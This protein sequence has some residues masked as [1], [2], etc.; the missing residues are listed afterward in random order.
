MSI[1]GRFSEFSNR[2][3]SGALVIGSHGVSRSAPVA[4]EPLELTYNPTNPSPQLLNNS[5]DNTQIVQSQN[6]LVTN[7]F[8]KESID[9]INAEESTILPEVITSAEPTIIVQE[10]D[11]L[12]NALRI[13]TAHS[14]IGFKQKKK[15][16][17][18][19]PVKAAA[20][21]G[22]FGI[23]IAGLVAVVQ[24]QTKWNIFQARANTESS[25]SITAANEDQFFANWI[26]I[27]FN[28]LV[29]KTGDEDQDGLTNYEEF[30]LGS[31]PAKYSTCGNNQSDAQNLVNLFDFGTCK[32]IDI[33]DPIQVA[34][35]STV[36]KIQQSRL[37][38]ENFS[39]SSQ[40][41]TSTQNNNLLSVF[42]VDSLDK[43]NISSS[44]SDKKEE[45][46]VTIAKINNYI[47]VHRSLETKDRELLPPLS[48]AYYLDISLRYNI[49]IKYIV[50]V[51][52]NS[53]KFGTDQ[54]DQNGA[55]NAI[56][57]S[58]N[59][60]AM[61]D[62]AGNLIKYNSWQESLEALGKWYQKISSTGAKD[63]DLWQAYDSASNYCQTIK[64]LA[65][66]FDANTSS[67][68]LSSSLPQPSNQTGELLP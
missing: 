37:V 22:V 29:D 51:A 14:K 9:K 55:P 4:I 18:R 15:K 34:K 68:M 1:A 64:T 35:I 54:Y 33:N 60:I 10:H 31:D 30:M 11:D 66:N 8:D 44:V 41:L 24:P 50:S 53:S 26:N 48:G 61:K 2:R 56:L 65:E 47:A 52:E 28:K 12:V 39:S 36:F 43:I 45:Y 59:L 38:L 7:S 21:F 58:K 5:I 6:L 32:P 25:S 46:S 63:C 27:H 16:P 20:V 67:S 62:G 42:G 19:D 57:Q 23:V 3:S 13:Q 40:S 49:P 17:T